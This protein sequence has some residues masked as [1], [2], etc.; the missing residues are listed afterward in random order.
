MPSALS[1]TKT[2]CPT[3]NLGSLNDTIK[4]LCPSP[5]PPAQP[6]VSSKPVSSKTSV[7]ASST[8]SQIPISTSPANTT[9]DT[10]TLASGSCG[11][12]RALSTATGVYG[13]GFGNASCPNVIPFLGEG[14]R[15]IGLVG[16]P[17]ILI[18][19]MTEIMLLLVN[20][21]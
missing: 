7:P 11:G 20:F 17:G 19:I 10:P 5:N 1:C 12:L 18:V 13:I 2:S 15:V 9:Y 6:S 4:N 16:P 3:S 14:T 8:D 21:F